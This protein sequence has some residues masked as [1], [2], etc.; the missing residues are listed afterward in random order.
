[1]AAALASG[2]AAL[3]VARDPKL[4]PAG[5]HQFMIRSARHIV[6]KRSD[7]GAGEIDALGAVEALSKQRRGE[8]RR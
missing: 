4:T 3:V 7:V 2:V 8:Y 5:V 6:G 1:M